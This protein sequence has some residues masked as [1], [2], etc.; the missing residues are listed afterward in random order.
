MLEDRLTTLDTISKL[1]FDR[2]WMIVATGLD[3]IKDI[4]SSP[5]LSSKHDEITTCAW[6]LMFNLISENSENQRKIWKECNEL[7][8][9]CL[10]QDF[11]K[12][13]TCR[14]VIYNIYARSDEGLDE[15]MTILTTLLN[16]FQHEKQ[17]EPLEE[18]GLT[19]FLEHFITEES[20]ISAMYLQL[21]NIEKMTLLQFT[22]DH[23]RR[24]EGNGVK[25]SISMALLHRICDDFTSKSEHTFH[26][27]IT[28]DI[29]LRELFAL[30]EVIAA[31]SH[32]ETYEFNRYNFEL[33]LNVGRL[34]SYTIANEEKAER[35]FSAVKRNCDRPLRLVILTTISNLIKGN[36]GHKERVSER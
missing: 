24:E 13:D 18:Q 20:N 7:F 28:D 33:V 35:T 36:N 11:C 16:S 32:E 27:S 34:L 14:L 10:Q 25:D 4:L 21:S 22:I 23:L 30:F 6:D 19:M 3:F 17:S 15:G 8:L 2:K 31:V 12:K 5:A 26:A 9:N 29:H 1:G